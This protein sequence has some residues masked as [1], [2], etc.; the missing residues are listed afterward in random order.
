MA[1]QT[2]QRAL[3]QRGNS[4]DSSITPAQ[5]SLLRERHIMWLDRQE[6]YLAWAGLI[7]AFVLALSFLGVSAWL[8][9][10]GHEVSGTILGTVDLVALVTVFITG[11][12]KV[13]T[14]ATV[15]ETREG[16]TTGTEQLGKHRRR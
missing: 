5:R 2:E 16:E 13:P 8:I 7:S 3:E 14:E 15:S 6:V 1:R 10:A 9:F 4:V 11:R 12:G